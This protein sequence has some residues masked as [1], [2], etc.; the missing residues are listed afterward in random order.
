MAVYI[1]HGDIL[2]FVFGFLFIVKIGLALLS[3]LGVVG[4]SILL[5]NL[6]LLNLIGSTLQNL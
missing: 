1:M 3:A 5:L 2:K 6:L 4:C